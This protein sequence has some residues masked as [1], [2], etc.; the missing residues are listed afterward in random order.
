MLMKT[1]NSLSIVNRVQGPESGQSLHLLLSGRLSHHLQAPSGGLKIFA[2]DFPLNLRYHIWGSQSP[3][4]KLYLCSA[5][6]IN[7]PNVCHLTEL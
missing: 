4:D 2:Y 7:I 5:A 3:D 6:A 1:K